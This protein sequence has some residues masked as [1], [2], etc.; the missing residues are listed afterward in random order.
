MSRNIITCLYCISKFNWAFIVTRKNRHFIPLFYTHLKVFMSRTEGK[1]GKPSRLCA[2]RAPSQGSPGSV[3]CPGYSLSPSFLFLKSLIS[4]ALSCMFSV[5]V[6]CRCCAKPHNQ[7]QH[8]EGRAYV[9]SQFQ[10]GSLQWGGRGDSRQSEQEAERS[11]LSYTQKAENEQPMTK[12]IN[13]RSNCPTP[14]GILLP[15]ELLI[16]KIP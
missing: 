11:H 6:T 7:K 10:R 16:R 12:V 9:G 13:P 8:K 5:L 1:D 15:T 14:C 3:L 4:S 2:G